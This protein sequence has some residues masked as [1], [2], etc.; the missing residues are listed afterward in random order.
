MAAYVALLKDALRPG[1]VLH[2]EGARKLDSLHPR[3]MLGKGL[4]AEHDDREEHK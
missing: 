1:S 2:G 3:K 4:W